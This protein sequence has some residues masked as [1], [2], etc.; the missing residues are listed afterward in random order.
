LDRKRFDEFGVSE[1]SDEAPEA[2]AAVDAADATRN[3][4]L[5]S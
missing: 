4:V 5:C 2:D 3:A 1:G